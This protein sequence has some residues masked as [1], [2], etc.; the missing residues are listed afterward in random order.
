[1]LTRWY[2]VISQMS[3]TLKKFNFG[4]SHFSCEGYHRE[5]RWRGFW[6]CHTLLWWFLQL[7][8]PPISSSL[9][10]REL[11][12]QLTMSLDALRSE[13]RGSAD[14]QLRQ[15]ELIS[16][17]KEETALMSQLESEMKETK[18]KYRELKHINDDQKEL[19]SR[20]NKVCQWIYSCLLIRLCLLFW[21]TV[22]LAFAVSFHCYLVGMCLCTCDCEPARLWPV[23]SD[24]IPL[25]AL[26]KTSLTL[27]MYKMPYALLLRNLWSRIAAKSMLPTTF[28]SEQCVLYIL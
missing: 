28:T 8:S 3:E 5:I 21:P 22:I 26:F 18:R 24:L 13:L 17:L 15:E 25:H 10:C 9:T 27:C 19:I 12:D 16:T 14:L 1:M 4:E 2:H 7:R 23:Q 11:T 6:R 20:L